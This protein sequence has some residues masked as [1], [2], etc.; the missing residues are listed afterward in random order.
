VRSSASVTASASWLATLNVT[1]P[2]LIL[3]GLGAQPCGV[4]LTVTVF[5]LAEPELAGEVGE[6]AH[7]AAAST[8]IAAMAATRVR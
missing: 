7:P 8:A 5:A 6:L 1:S 2:A 3:A 4:R